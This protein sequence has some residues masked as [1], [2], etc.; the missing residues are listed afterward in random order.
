MDFIVHQSLKIVESGVIP[1]HAIRA[2]IRALSKKRLIQEGRYD[3]EQGAQRY[4]D[5]LN[6]LKRAKSPLKQ[7]RQT[8]S[9]MSYQPSFFRRCLEKDL[10]IVHVTFPLKQQ[11]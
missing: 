10:N 6:M 11:L 2:A 3:P 7:I 5:V 9:T 4:M 1:D 8:S